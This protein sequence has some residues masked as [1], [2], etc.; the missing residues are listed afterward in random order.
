MKPVTGFAALIAKIF[1]N[2][3]R[4]TFAIRL[5]TSLILGKFGIVGPAA[6]LIGYFLRGILGFAAETGIFQIDLAISALREGMKLKEF[7]R[8]AA[9]AYKKATAKIYDEATKNAIRKEYLEIIS[10]FGN[11]G[12]DRP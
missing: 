8:E 11:V 6:D 3:Y 2:T 12:D 5:G 1:S 4:D 10:K 9:A 7:E